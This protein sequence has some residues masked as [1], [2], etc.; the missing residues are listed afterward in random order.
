MTATNVAEKSSKATANTEPPTPSGL[1]AYLRIF[2]NGDAKLYALEAVAII[3][4]ITSGVAL[5]LVNVV[6]GNFVTI[7]GNATDGGLFPDGFM[8]RVQ[9]AALRFVYIGIARFCGT[10]IYASL[11]TYVAHRMTRNIRCAYLR[12]ALSQEIAFFDQGA[13]GSIAMQATTNGKL[14]QSGTAEKLGLFVQAM[15]TFI[16]AFVVAFIADWKLTLIIS[17]IIPALLLISGLVA[18]LDVIV[19]T[20]MLQVY[21]Q[22]GSYSESILGGIR[23]VHAF[24]LRNRLVAKYKADFLDDAY[25]RGMK[26]NVLYGILFG[27]EYSVLYCGMGLAFWQGINMVDRGEIDN[28][29]VVFTV[30]FSIVIAA[31]MITSI[32]PHMLAFGRAATAAAELFTLIDR[33]SAIDPFSEHGEKPRHVSGDIEIQDL[34]FAY[35]NR[36]EATVLQDFTLRVPAGK[37]TAL[38][39]PSGSGKSTIIGLLERWYD[40]RQGRITL[41]GIGLGD[42]NLRWL[43]TNVRLV[44]QEPVLFNG[45]VF[46]NIVK[47]L[48][49]T[50]W[51]DASTE[52]KKRRV[53]NAAE[54]AFAHDFI[55]D[56]AQGYDTHIG[57]RGSLLSGGQKQRI[58]IARSIISE[59]K[60][61]LL[62]EATS[63]LDPQAEGIVQKALDNASRNRTTITIAHKLATIR[64]AD[65]IVVMSHGRIAEQGTHEQLCSQGGLYEKLVRAQDLAPSSDAASNKTAVEDDSAD[66]DLEP[67]LALTKTHTRETSELAALQAREDFESYKPL[68]FFRTIAKLVKL[69]PELR[70]W[71]ILT[72]VTCV[73]GAAIFPGQAILLAQVLD[74][75]SSPNMVSRGNFFALM[76]FVM[77]L[78]C[79]VA[80]FIMGWACN[81]IG[82]VLTRRTRHELFD[83]IL[84]QDLRFFDRPENTVGSLMSK[85]D[86]YPQSIFELMGMNVGLI[87]IAGINV[88][89]SAILALAISWRVAVIGVFV[90]LPPMLVAGYARVRLEA[91][92]DADMG[93]RYAASSSV[94]SETTTAI[95]TVSS[96][97]IEQSVL[98]HYAEELD[99]AIH[100]ALPGLFNMMIW[101]ALTQSIE[102]F[103]LSL[104]FWWGSKLIF[105]EKVTFYQFIASFMAVY[106]SGQGAGQMFSFSSSFSKAI[107]A[108]N[109]Y[110]WLR[111]LEPIIRETDRNRDMAPVEGCKSFE[112][113]K[114]RFSYPT[115]PDIRILQG[116]SL[117][118]NP[119]EFVAFVGASGCGKSTLISLLNRF[120]D[121]TSGT[122]T[123]DG[124]HPLPALNPALYRQNVALVQQEP[125]LFPGTIRDN[126][127]HGLPESS[128]SPSSGSA[129]ATTDAQIEQ[130]CRAANAWTFIASLPEG[131][132]TP[133]GQGGGQ[134]SGGQRQRVAIARALVRDPAVLLLDEATS[135]LDT[136]SER[137]VQ[138]ALAQAS[139]R[140]ADG[141]GRVTVAVAHRL[142]TIRAA[143]R[144]FV[145]FGGAVVEVGTH[146]ELVQRGGMYAKM[147]EAQ[148]LAV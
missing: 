108:A 131:L 142:S 81:M 4:A 46:D 89:I 94:A 11:F 143:D 117:T 59:P 104:G 1:K 67:R 53:Q 47:G 124:A 20:G 30:V 39:G 91:R 38:V 58:A 5:A 63:A 32:A 56:L 133:C 33:K 25:K 95:R 26:K 44:Q 50:A 97:A 86:S 105:E 36:P 80:Y 75:A 31:M 78:G 48:I 24:G 148:N 13:S 10:Y 37:V 12:A 77:G 83:C 147:C 100:N 6:L 112:L 127:A 92:I 119:G 125:T 16:A 55:T 103:I 139:A 130:A 64:G 3:A 87:T 27:G 72:L 136:E 49:G 146:E 123:V 144:I 65:N 40:P 23:A 22:A 34:T 61:L 82:Q 43:R 28:I 99:A 109:Y 135:A 128:S 35:P 68:G 118:I 69:T 45:T 137:V 145:F 98:A 113:E 15:S 21:G 74:T 76:F 41:D 71:Y 42:L 73:A 70:A 138:A 85:L 141:G 114:I 93:K 7:L 84:K 121:P 18:W 17:C 134:L 102:Y 96:L 106:F 54:L 14:I 66:S 110:F 115:A 51:E 90:G 2:T 111:D 8:S 126:I 122:I 116:V 52:E 29:G 62:D 60:I 19:E 88:L 101:F 107:Q 129:A 57:Q 132:D 140:R 79:F 120:Y 9:T